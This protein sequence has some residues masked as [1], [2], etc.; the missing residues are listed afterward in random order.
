MRIR[1]LLTILSG[2][3]LIFS[4]SLLAHTS[5][6]GTG[7]MGGLLHP[8]TGIDH[9]LLLFLAVICIISILRWQKNNL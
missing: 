8:F 6:S 3:S 2:L 7:L 4:S 5:D 9:L 1:S